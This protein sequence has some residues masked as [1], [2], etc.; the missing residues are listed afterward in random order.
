MG[1][2]AIVA[3]FQFM[4]WLSSVYLI[5]LTRVAAEGNPIAAPFFASGAGLLVLSIGKIGAFPFLYWLAVHDWRGHFSGFP[6]F[7][8]GMVMV[9]V[10]IILP[11]EIP[12]TLHNMVLAELAKAAG[13]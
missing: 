1:L 11:I 4:D 10:F 9:G 8:P 12:V 3:M 6:T 13:F 7:I 2:V 5:S